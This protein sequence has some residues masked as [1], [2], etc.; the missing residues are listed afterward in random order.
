M[1]ESPLFLPQS[2]KVEEAMQAI[3]LILRRC[4]SQFDYKRS[5][6]TLSMLME[7]CDWQQVT[8]EAG[9]SQILKR[10]RISYQR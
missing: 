9:M 1:D 4:L 6:R 5:R 7:T 8:T 10:L 2:P 3:L